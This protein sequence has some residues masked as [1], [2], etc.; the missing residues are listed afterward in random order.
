MLLIRLFGR[1]VYITQITIVIIQ[2]VLTKRK[3]SI[4]ILLS[5]I[6]SHLT[7]LTVKKLRRIRFYL[8]RPISEFF[9]EVLRY[10]KSL[11]K[12]IKIQ[13]N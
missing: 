6:G 3:F 8:V 1:F 2:L 13:A 11:L 9:A 10:I 5:L 4:C 7:I 12:N